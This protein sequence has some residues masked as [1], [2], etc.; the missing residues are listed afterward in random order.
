MRNA[1]LTLLLFGLLAASAN[2]A[3]FYEGLTLARLRGSAVGPTGDSVWDGLVAYYGLDSTNVTDESSNN[4]SGTWGSATVLTNVAKYGYAASVSGAANSWFSLGLNWHPGDI[5]TN[6]W[7]GGR[8]WSA[9]MWVYLRARTEF[10]GIIST[11]SGATP[12][13][14]GLL[15]NATI[16]NTSYY[17]VGVYKPDTWVF[18]GGSATGAAFP[19]TGVWV[20]TAMTVDTLYDNG[21]SGTQQVVRLYANGVQYFS[22]ESANTE[23]RKL[24]SRRYSE[25]GYPFRIG[26]DRTFSGRVS[27]GIFDEVAIFNRALSSNEVY[28]IATEQLIYRKQ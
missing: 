16:T 7:N 10:G 2:P 21:G 13:L 27:N 26:T 1:I 24:F 6:T 8:G 19:T 9:S 17:G 23:D 12:D 25:G 11:I 20:H 14:Y 15:Q 3:A 4:F 5:G 28:R 22:R 18:I